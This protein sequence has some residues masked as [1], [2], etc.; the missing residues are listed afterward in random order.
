MVYIALIAEFFILFV[1]LLT[2]SIVKNIKLKTKERC[3]SV[4]TINKIKN[5]ITINSKYVTVII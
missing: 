5:C 4:F 1:K 3:Y 2:I